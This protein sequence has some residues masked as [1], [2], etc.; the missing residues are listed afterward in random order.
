MS[1]SI[2]T[3]PKVLQAPGTL[4]EGLGSLWSLFNPLE[5][6][7]WTFLAATMADTAFPSLGV[8]VPCCQL[9]A[10]EE[11][12]SLCRCGH[13]HHLMSETWYHVLGLGLL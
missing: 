4:A 12:P 6:E 10:Q 2:G 13:I 11:S 9:S 7:V 5:P 1:E 8:S 3:E